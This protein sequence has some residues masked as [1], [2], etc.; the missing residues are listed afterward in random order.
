MVHIHLTRNIYES[1]ILSQPHWNSV[2]TVRTKFSF[3]KQFKA[4]GAI[5]QSNY[6]WK[7]WWFGCEILVFINTCNHQLH[8][9]FKFLFVKNITNQFLSPM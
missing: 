9:P 1:A 5:I 2:V 6:C 3:K 7:Q 8:V 4:S